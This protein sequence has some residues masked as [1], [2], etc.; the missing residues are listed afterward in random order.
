[1]IVFVGIGLKLLTNDRGA[2]PSNIGDSST[3]S[4]QPNTAEVAP[5]RDISPELIRTA[6]G[7][8]EKAEMELANKYLLLQDYDGA[9]KWFAAAAE[10]KNPDALNALG[11]LSESGQGMPQSWTRGADYFLEATRISGHYEESA[12]LKFAEAALTAAD[13]RVGNGADECSG[14]R[15]LYRFLAQRGNMEAEFELAEMDVGIDDNNLLHEPHADVYRSGSCPS[16][17]DIYDRQGVAEMHASVLARLLSLARRDYLPAIDVLSFYYQHESTVDQ[18]ERCTE[19][20]KWTAKLN[21]RAP[22]WNLY[23]Q[24]AYMYW[25][26]CSECRACPSNLKKA[27]TAICKAEQIAYT[28]PA[29]DQV[30]E[31]KRDFLAQISASELPYY[32][33]GCR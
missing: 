33:Q 28:Q 3:S 26:G 8:N 16:S 18:Q 23:L 21:Q 19:A 4:T 29:K 20:E 2:S 30:A 9:V 15:S 6:S 24:E 5:S 25:N 32:L 7:G 22:L 13:G 14:A 10:K 11:L 1:M 12:F 31:E 27:F 17:V